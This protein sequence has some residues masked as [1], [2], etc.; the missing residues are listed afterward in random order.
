MQQLQQHGEPGVGAV[1]ARQRHALPRCAPL[2]LQGL[3]V[4]RFH[5]ADALQAVQQGDAVGGGICGEGGFQRRGEG[6]GQLAGDITEGG[7]QVRVAVG[8]H[9]GFLMR[10][11]KEPPCLTARVADGAWLQYR[12][13]TLPAGAIQREWTT[14][15]GKRKQH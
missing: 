12:R 13:L 7:E 2:A 6:V 3:A 5:V 11:A 9:G 8:A 14:P 1:D 10:Y 15:T 4:G